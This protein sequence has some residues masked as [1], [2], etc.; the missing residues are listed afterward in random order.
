MIKENINTFSEESEHINGGGNFQIN[1]DVQS[2]QCYAKEISAEEK[3][4]LRCQSLMEN[5]KRE[6]KTE[7]FYKYDEHDVL[8]EV[9]PHT[10]QTEESKREEAVLYSIT[11]DKELIKD[12][13]NLLEQWEIEQ[14]STVRWLLH[15][16]M[17][18]IETDISKVEL[19]LVIVSAIK[20][21]TPKTDVLERL[22][23]KKNFS[24]D[25]IREF[26]YLIK[27]YGDTTSD[28]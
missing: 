14:V 13:A 10:T 20:V 4:F 8:M 21:A 25:F 9:L 1:E 17:D 18:F 11:K 23:N 2:K 22:Q 16:I 27:K 19:M 26:T 28:F 7:Y 24:D 15:S 3:E 12:L 5:Y 6:Y